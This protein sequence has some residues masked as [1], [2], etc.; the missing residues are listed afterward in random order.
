MCWSALHA[1]PAVHTGM[2]SHLHGGAHVHSAPSPSPVQ[3]GGALRTHL[4]R[5]SPEKGSTFS[6]Q[7]FQGLQCSR[8]VCHQD[9]WP[10]CGQP[11]ATHRWLARAYLQTT[12]TERS[13]SYHRISKQSDLATLRW[14]GGV[15]FKNTFWITFLIVS[16]P[17]R[18]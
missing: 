14:E 8:A 4:P 13:E 1:I 15:F 7:I 17:V 2:A 9:G 3:T 18:L 10:V 6:G 16:G 11:W 12:P 5:K